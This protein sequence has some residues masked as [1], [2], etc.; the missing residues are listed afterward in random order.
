MESYIHVLATVLKYV[1]IEQNIPIIP[2]IAERNA[3][4]LVTCQGRYLKTH[5]VT[6]VSKIPPELPYFLIFCERNCNI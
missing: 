5:F 1:L 4:V 3:V 2:L 6:Q